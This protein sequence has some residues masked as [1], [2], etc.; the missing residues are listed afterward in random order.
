[1]LN[2]VGPRQAYSKEESAIKDLY[3]QVVRL[4]KGQPDL[5]DEFVDFLPAA[6]TAAALC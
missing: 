2:G 3:G 6:V 5:L 4:F 1:M